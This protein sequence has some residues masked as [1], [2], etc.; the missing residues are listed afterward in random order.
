MVDAMI[1]QM[2]VPVI[3]LPSHVSFTVHY[4]DMRDVSHLFAISVMT[5]DLCTKLT[6]LHVTFSIKEGRFTGDLNHFAS[7]EPLIQRFTETLNS[8]LE[9]PKPLR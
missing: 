6:A 4:L 8:R 5:S 7:I 9:T 3:Y 1:L 2:M